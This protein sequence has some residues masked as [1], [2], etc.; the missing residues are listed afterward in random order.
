MVRLA[1]AEGGLGSFL[2]LIRTTTNRLDLTNRGPAL[3]SYK[4]VS[5]RAWLIRSGP[6]CVA[7]RIAQSG[8]DKH[9]KRKGVCAP[10]AGFVLFAILV[11][12]L[13]A[14]PS[15]ASNFQQFYHSTP[16]SEVVQDAAGAAERWWNTLTEEERVRALYGDSATDEQD[17]AA[18]KPYE[19]LDEETKALV[20]EAAAELYG[21][22]DFKSV[23]EW[24]ETLD[25]RL[26]RVAV[27]DGNEDDPTSAYCAHYPGSEMEPVLGDAQRDRV[28]EVGIALFD[29]LD[30][31]IYPTPEDLDFAN[32]WWDALDNDQRVGAL[33]GEAGGSE[34]ER[35]AAMNSYMDLFSTT[36]KLV[37]DTATEVNGAGD[38]D[39]VGTWWQSLDCR[40]RRVATGEGNEADASS[41]FCANYPGSGQEPI[42][43]DAEKAHVDVVGQGL[44]GRDDPGIFPPPPDVEVARRWWDVLLGVQRVRAIY[45]LEATL[46]QVADAS[47]D[48][49][50][51]SNETKVLVNEYA[52]EL[53][54]TGDF[55]SVGD[56]WQTLDCRQRRIVMGVGN[57]DD[58]ENVFCRNYPGSGGDP[59]QILGVL[60]RQAVD[61]VGTAF[62]GLDDPGIYLPEVNERVNRVHQ[63]V[64]LELARAM[65]ASSVDAVTARIDNAMSSATELRLGLG[66]VDLISDM[67]RTGKN[68]GDDSQAWFWKS[69]AGKTLAFPLGRNASERE[70]GGLSLWGTGD[71][72]EMVGTRRSFVLWEG[73]LR[74]VHLGLD[75]RLG[76]RLLAGLVGS[77]HEGSLEYFD[78]SNGQVRQGEYEVNLSSYGPYVAW[79]TRAGRRLWV[80]LGSGAGE[81]TISDDQLEVP[82]TTEFSQ[83]SLAMGSLGDI[84]ER[85][86]EFWG[87]DYRT[88][89]TLKAEMS[90]T[91]L[92]AEET[93]T[94][95]E[96][97]GRN[98]RLKFMVEV[99]NSGG[100]SDGIQHMQYFA[101]GGRNDQGD[102]HGASGA[103]REGGFLFRAKGLTLRVD[104][105]YLAVDNF[106]PEERGIRGMLQLDPGPANMGLWMR[107][108]P[109]WGSP[110]GQGSRFLE[111][112]FS[113]FMGIGMQD[114]SS[115][116][117]LASEVGYIL[118]AFDGRGSLNV[119]SS[120]TSG[121]TTSA[122]QRVG[123]QVRLPP[124]FSF[125]AEGRRQQTSN[126]SG[127]ARYG[128]ELRAS[129]HW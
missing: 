79:E 52:L 82:G 98:R 48:Y 77:S 80:L 36:K 43:R 93:A 109:S 99:S 87:S 12:G 39:S 32:G 126:L 76:P 129:L 97:S 100:K 108:M 37:N 29:F 115:D 86:Y 120:M 1:Y 81:V 57:D 69:L 26:Q 28:D 65:H 111:T 105:H 30:A 55:P 121:S 14:Q 112:G 2:R 27:G 44:L 117:R 13:V 38:W 75:M 15:I 11:G 33:Y 18:R 54:G 60:E 101:F 90:Y 95:D 104:V 3:M 50:N 83:T 42:L 47:R 16:T 85:D 72:R 113:S 64:I 122:L 9:A 123:M 59:E 127:G 46:D 68:D 102:G 5:N 128:V 103:L 51:I 118:P 10:G 96:F 66:V 20:D 53:Y 92:S 24:W 89:V 22:G 41:P 7:R 78:F 94:I 124:T 6:Q 56:W 125:S 88:V 91:S 116:K 4:T 62:L 58:P 63:K 21:D 45:G 19:E 61:V 71:Y 31:G 74:S 23:G 73:T 119:Y 25:C 84:F 35:A 17:E 8:V 34:E 107:V 49:D 114:T 67:A 110:I 40:L 70:K 106:E